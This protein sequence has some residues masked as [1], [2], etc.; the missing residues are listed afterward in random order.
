MAVFHVLISIIVVGLLGIGIKLVNQSEDGAVVVGKEKMHAMHFEKYGTP[1]EV[2]LKSELPIPYYRSWEVLVEVHAA[3]L[4]PVDYKIIDGVF[5]LIDFALTHIPGF[6]FSGRVIAVGKDVKSIK[7]GDIVHGMTW[8][9]KT[10]SLAEYLAIDES[11]I[12]I[13]PDSISSQE[14]AAL[15]L[16]THTSYA[17]LVTLGGLAM[18]KQQRV[19]VLGGGSATGMMAVQLVC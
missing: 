13:V 12:N 3:S 15:P 10:G 19:L 17:S 11:A 9:H 16:V 8:V 14:A 18:G 6:D 1:S 2:L 5:Y 4:N 7:V